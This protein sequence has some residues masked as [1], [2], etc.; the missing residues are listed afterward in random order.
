MGLDPAG[1]TEE[2]ADKYFGEEH[3][4]LFAALPA[5]LITDSHPDHLTEDSLRLI[6]PLTGAEDRLGNLH[7]L[8]DALASL[9]RDRDPSFLE[10]F[11]EPNEV[12]NDAN[13]IVDLKPNFYG[14]GININALIERFRRA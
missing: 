7:A 12:V 4:K 9:A 10:R 13:S 1:S 2:V 6:I 3:D 5:L 8:F 14:I 11:Q